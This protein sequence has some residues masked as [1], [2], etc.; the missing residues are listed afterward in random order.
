VGRHAG[1]S[2]IAPQI[3]DQHSLLE[4]LVENTVLYI[5]SVREL[6]FN[7]KNAPE[8]SEEGLTSEIQ[9]PY[10]TDKRGVVFGGR[11]TWI[12]A[13]RPMLPNVTFINKWQTPNTDMIRAAEVMWIQPSAR[14]CAVHGYGG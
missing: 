12:K 14:K 2:G 4:R 11:D 9:F 10:Q 5:I 3:A 13:I 6:V 7:Q 1:I 8:E